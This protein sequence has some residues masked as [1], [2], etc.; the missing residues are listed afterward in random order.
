MSQ[1]EHQQRVKEFLIK[2][3]QTVRTTPQLPPRE[4]CLTRAQLIYEECLEKITALGMSIVV[5]VGNQRVPALISIED[6]GNSAN[7][8]EIV[9]GCI[10]LSVVLQ[11]T[12]LACGVDDKELLEEIDSNNLAKFGP[13]G[14]K[15]ENG[16]WIK[17]PGHPKPDILGILTKQGYVAE[18]NTEYSH[19]G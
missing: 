2:A 7:L 4:E 14:Y 19:D 13:G 6:K 18:V 11:G 8:I 17:P 16:K 9:D 15:N 12:L 10:D 1:T 5:K 3:G